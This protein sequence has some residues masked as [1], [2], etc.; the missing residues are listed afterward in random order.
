MKVKKL[1]LNDQ[2][3]WPNTIT[4]EIRMLLI[5]RTKTSEKFYLS[6]KSGLVWK[7]FTLKY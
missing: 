3:V 2:G 4:D 5:D 6:H 1:D 7:F